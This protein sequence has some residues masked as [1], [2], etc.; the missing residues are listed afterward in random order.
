MSCPQIFLF[1]LYPHNIVMDSVHVSFEFMERLK[2]D[3]QVI[4]HVIRPAKSEE[5]LVQSFG[6]RTMSF[7]AC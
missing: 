2:I 5:C 4:T 1:L 6:L 3:S 7:P